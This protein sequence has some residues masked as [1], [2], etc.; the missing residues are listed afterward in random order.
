MKVE[1][2]GKDF[3][4]KNLVNCGDI[5][6]HKSCSCDCGY[7]NFMD[8]KTFDIIGMCSTNNGLMLVFECEKCFQDYKH[9]LGTNKFDLEEFKEDAG[10]LLHKKKYRT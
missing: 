4:L 3:N 5:P 6:Y 10:Q 2:G 7:A 1:F 8:I 9:H